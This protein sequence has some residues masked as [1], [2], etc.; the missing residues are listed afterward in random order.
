[1]S[2]PFIVF[3]FCL[4]PTQCRL[5]TLF[6]LVESE[7]EVDPAPRSCADRPPGGHKSQKHQLPQL[8]SQGLFRFS[9][10]CLLKF[11]KTNYFYF[12]LE[13]KS[14]VFDQK[15][16]DIFNKSSVFTLVLSLTLL[17]LIVPTVQLQTG[18]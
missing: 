2:S 15:P 14:E 4:S 17:R 11:H 5:K 6:K 8:G 3:S 13:K 9:H 7:V 12:F 10:S 18:L 1:M 16:L